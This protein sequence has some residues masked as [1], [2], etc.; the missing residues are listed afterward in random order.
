MSSPSAVTAVSRAS[1]WNIRFV[2]PAPDNRCVAGTFQPRRADGPL[3]LTWSQLFRDLLLC[4][5]LP[6]SPAAGPHDRVLALWLRQ[7]SAAAAVAPCIYFPPYQS[8]QQQQLGGVYIDVEQ[9][10]PMD[11][12]VMGDTD[13]DDDDD[14]GGD[15]DS[16]DRGA[17]GD[18][19]RAAM[20]HLD[21]T[22]VVH[23]R[24]CLLMIERDLE[25]HLAAGM[26]LS[27]PLQI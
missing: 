12:A 13:D 8:E 10:V 19:A 25:A 9:L 5:D 17:E 27:S 16:R 24:D 3:F 26:G 21:L 14:D 4:F 1:A 7:K 23:A 2:E 18:E 11:E 15:G 20:S 6:M 22:V